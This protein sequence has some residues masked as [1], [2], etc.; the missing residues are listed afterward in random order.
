M[1]ILVTYTSNY[2]RRLQPLYIIEIF[3]RK[4]DTHRRFKTSSTAL[5]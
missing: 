5:K 3:A 1:C 2:S 4:V